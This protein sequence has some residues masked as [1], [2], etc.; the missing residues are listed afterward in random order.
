MHR[1]V[2]VRP[3]GAGWRY[4][5]EYGCTNR[6]PNVSVC[7]YE[8]DGSQRASWSHGV[9]NSCLPCSD[10]T[11]LIGQLGACGLSVHYNEFVHRILLHCVRCYYNNS[12]TS[13]FIKF[14]PNDLY[15]PQWDEGVQ[16]DTL[17]HFRPELTTPLYSHS[18]CI[19]H[20]KMRK[21]PRELSRGL[22]ETILSQGRGWIVPLF[23]GHSPSRQPLLPA[24]LLVLRWHLAGS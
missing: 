13:T 19:V 12:K 11:S 1:Y 20:L 23:M 17:R 18:R 2:L 6:S 24:S 15:L 9:S 7:R 3:Q 10:C 22:L 21:D 8:Y 14:S 16:S 5:Q 4:T